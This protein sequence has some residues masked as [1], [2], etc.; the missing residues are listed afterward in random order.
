MANPTAHPL[1]EE[2]SL[3]HVTVRRILDIIIL[4]LQLSL[5]VYR[6]FNL[7]NNGFTWLL[8]FLCELWFTIDWILSLC[9]IWTP[10]DYKTYPENLINQ[11]AELPAVDMFVTTA[12]PVLEPPIITVNTVLSLLAVD[13]PADK[14]ACYVSDDGCSPITFY[15]LVEASKFAQLWVPFCKKYNVQLR[16][17]FRYFSVK[18]IS[19]TYESLEFQQEWGKMKEEY[20][21]FCQKVEE[22]HK[23]VPS[24]LSADYAAFKDIESKNHPSII[25][26]IWENKNG[27]ADGLL[28]HLIY[29]SREKRP[30]MSHHYKAGAMNVL[31]RISGLMTNAPYMLNVDCDMYA[32]NPKIVLHAMCLML[33]LKQNESNCAFVQFP[34]MF[35]DELKDDPFGNQMVIGF[36]AF[37][38]GMGGI[39]GPIY[40]GTGCFHT[41]QVIYGL[42]PSN[43]DI[44]GKLMKEVLEQQF[45][46]SKKFTKSVSE[47][48]CGLEEKTFCQDSVLS[49][50]EEAYKVSSCSYERSTGWGNKVGWFYG[51]ATEDV[52]TGMRIHARGWKSA[53]CMP[54][55]PAFM[56]CSAIGGPEFMIQRKRWA[57]GVSEILVS[58]HNPIFVALTSKLQFRQSLAYTWILMWGIRC[59][60]ELSYAVLSA[61]CLITNTSFLPKVN[62][63][64]AMV[65]IALF[66]IQY[67]ETLVSYLRVGLSVRAWWN[68]MRMS[69]INAASSQLFGVLGV[70]LKLLGLSET[71][72]EVTQKDQFTSND[73]GNSTKADA[74][75]FTFSDSPIF[76]LPTT[77]LLLQLTALVMAFLVLQPPAHGGHGAGLL[78]I[79]CSIWVVLCFWPFLKGL[80]GKG[81]QGIPVLTKLKAAGLALIFLHLSKRVSMV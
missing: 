72:F 65:P 42:S 56:G 55:P 25:K 68:N 4:F 5:L 63:A 46:Y 38:L 7:N 47:T 29:I 62:E 57:T 64:A 44:N 76:V 34:Q 70:I 6:F 78:E 8:A 58:K 36:E 45:G 50:I 41:R 73:E 71:V 37:G 31:T 13:Y 24:N 32:N 61:Y 66:L 74:S 3:K 1:Y 22:A 15:S 9:I 28:P 10:I 67:I 51:S 79:M 30:N 20:E 16:A 2:I 43:T 60:P 40:A 21:K 33:G 14:L 48:L 12:D 23:L 27:F 75:V 19:S 53:L 39:Q 49:S 11:V 54:D 59:I 52:L 81:K 18:P 77:L 69:K 35:Y 80:L 17:P 26:V